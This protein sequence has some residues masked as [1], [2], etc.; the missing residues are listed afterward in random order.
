[1]R[2]AHRKLAKVERKIESALIYSR[3]HG[4]W[5]IFTVDRNF[6]P[7][8]TASKML[9]P[10]GYPYINLTYNQPKGAPS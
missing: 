6:E 7:I 1:M 3:N 2:L 8:F 5:L 10:A 4:F 9:G